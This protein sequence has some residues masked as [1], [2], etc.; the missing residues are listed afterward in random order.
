MK[1]MKAQPIKLNPEQAEAFMKVLQEIEASNNQPQ[2]V[3]DDS[4]GQE[5]TMDKT[6]TGQLGLD[7]RDNW[8]QNIST[9]AECNPEETIGSMVDL[10][11]A[12][13]KALGPDRTINFIR[14]TEYTR[15]V[16][17]I[18]APL[19]ATP[20]I[21]AYMDPTHAFYYRNALIELFHAR[22]SM[23][24]EIYLSAIYE[25]MTGRN[26]DDVYYPSAKGRIPYAFECLARLETYCNN[27]FGSLNGSMYSI[28]ADAILSYIL[29]CDHCSITEENSAEYYCEAVLKLSAVLMALANAAQI[30]IALGAIP[31]RN[32]ENIGVLPGYKFDFDR[33]LRFQSE[34]TEYN[35]IQKIYVI[36]KSSD[37]YRS[38]E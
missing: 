13:D 29:S 32:P 19:T 25:E 21:D 38:E 6:I 26:L 9:N 20:A 10:C 31:S 12:C 11:N 8:A 36:N 22:A 4:V 15:K 16:A 5:I 28:Y 30:Y 2:V 14:E 34:N 33:P 35:R 18:M 17:A 7:P 27:G 24:F 3:E 1:M 37:L 23:V